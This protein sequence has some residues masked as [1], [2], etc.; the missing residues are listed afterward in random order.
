MDVEFSEQQRLIQDSAR[1]FL[2]SRFTR[3][4][5]CGARTDPEGC[6]AQN[7]TDMSDL[8]WMAIR[9]PESYDGI[10][11]SFVD[12][13]VLLEEMGRVALP[14][15]FFSTAVHGVEILRECDNR[16][17]K[18]DI[19][20]SVATGQTKLA[21]ALGNDD[22]EFGPSAA[23]F[24]A[25]PD[26]N[27][28][29]LNGFSQYVQNGHNADYI[30]C[31]ARMGQCEEPE[32]D[33]GLF[34][35]AT[36]KQGVCRKPLVTV[37]GICASE[38]VLENVHVGRADL[39]AE[40]G[41]LWLALEQASFRSAVAKSAEMIGAAARI[42][43]I[44]VAHAKERHQFGKAIGSFQAIQHHCADML[45]D[46]DSAR[47]MMYKT[48]WL[49]DE[50]QATRQDMAMTKIW[51]NEACRRILRSGHQVMG[52]IG[53]CEEHD[54]P[55][56]FR[57]LRLAESTLGGTDDHLAVVADDLLSEDTPMISGNKK[58]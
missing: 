55:M 24:T 22:G 30:L 54:M 41:N 5:V 45:T 15:P 19:L 6:S 9:V 47:W 40:D 34:R 4:L 53:Y 46:L 48:G 39:I 13:L 18:E 38:V 49:I 58:G 16:K 35:V 28:Y 26:D 36:D 52:G 12:L 32:K 42:L 11:G 7:W 8:G 23:C 29:L 3:Q 56:F 1:S 2:S 25:N 44:A 21:V 37:N 17:I 51:C 43:E 33:I 27:G 10:G 20:S 31:A 50:G 57:Y 14:G